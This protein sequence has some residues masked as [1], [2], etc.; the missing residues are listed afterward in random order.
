MTSILILLGKYT[1]IF[2]FLRN[3]PDYSHLL[4]KLRINLPSLFKGCEFD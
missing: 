4:I 1:H 3:F 2:L